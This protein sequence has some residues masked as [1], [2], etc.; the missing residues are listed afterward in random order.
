METHMSR[1]YIEVAPGSRH[2]IR[3]RLAL[4]ALA[5]VIAAMTAPPAGA[6]TLP[7][8]FQESTVFSG[9]T[10][11]TVVRFASDGR[12]FVGT[13]SGRIYVFDSTTD[14][15]PTLFADLSPNVHDYWDRGLLGLALDPQFPSRPYVYALYTY[16][17][18]TG[19]ANLITNPSFETDTSGWS[20]SGDAPTTMARQTGWSA[21][22]AA[23]LRYTATVGTKG[24]SGAEFGY[25]GG[26]SVTPGTTYAMSAVVNVLSLTGA[27]KVGGY[28][29]W[30]DANWNWLGQSAFNKSPSLGVRTISGTAT[31]PTGARYATVAALADEGTGQADFYVD[32]ASFG[33]PNST[34]T[35]GDQCPTPPGPTTNGCVV[36]GR[37]SRLT[38]A[39]NTM[40]GSEQVLIE[41][42]CQQFPSHSIGTL[43]FAPDGSLYVTG[44]EGASFNYADYGQTGNPCGDPPG[45]VGSNLSPPAAEGGALRSQDV[46]STADPTGLDGAV[47]RVNPDTGQG[48]AGNPYA[49]STDANARRIV[50]YGLRNPFRAVV[51]PGT[52][53]LWLGDVGW[54]TWEEIDRMVS[55][56]QG[57]NFGWPCYEGTA[58]QPSYDS[59]NL[60]LC[61]GL[62]SVGAVVAPRFTYNHA[63]TVAGSGDPCPTGSSSISGLAFGTSATT[64]PAPFDR[65]LFFADYSRDCIWAMP[66]G[67]D[68]L[69]DPAAVRTFATGLATGPVDLVIGPDGDLYYAGLNSGTV[70]RISYTAGNRAPVAVA[71]ATPTSGNSP[72]TVQFDGTGSSDPD[73]GDTLSY[74]WDLDGNGVY[75]NSTSSRPTWTY[76]TDGTYTPRLRVT[77]NHGS[78]A[79]DSVTINV[80]NTPP[81][82]TITAPTSSVTWSVGDVIGFSGS[83]TDP[84]Q[85]TLPAS[86]LSWDLIMHH[87][88]SNCHEHY[89]Q[90]FSGATGSFTAPDHEYPSYLELRL[91]AT[92]SGG[93][94][95]TQSVRLDPRT[96]NLTLASKPF[97]GLY[98]TLN[99]VTAQ[100]K[101]TRT[102]IQNSSNSISAPDQG[103][104]LFR[105]WSD[106]GA[107]THQIQPGTSRTYTATF[108]KR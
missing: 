92:D 34:S 52:S 62:Y 91:T 40:T 60:N 47:L 56:T 7:S 10:N 32:S 97:N 5:V 50:A 99:G 44:G 20:Y 53:E 45:S 79:T 86:A 77:D 49:G 11:P 102:V 16:D 76:Q 8:G 35:W 1:P 80:G 14:T 66:L 108:R 39:G 63:A 9:I 70:R 67:A 37:L 21:S 103:Q 100:A 61:E 3:I 19:G 18:R 25:R 68:G 89:I 29:S 15:T 4:L 13:K 33:D 55:P 12:V 95:G 22:G 42:W 107:Q 24:W 27:Q 104:Y 51:R 74:A 78:S 46:R 59:L 73:P 64:Y 98:L 2:R 94:K 69:P 6:V 105:S 85:G 83:A 72:L 90:G 101:F 93:L 26:M 43:A 82:A 75:D 36:G 41:D 65:A 84:Q 96:V 28:L 30:W 38:A 106:G 23:S 81:T 88:P 71:Q 57:A 54:S 17:H 48:V 87:C 31:A 58:P